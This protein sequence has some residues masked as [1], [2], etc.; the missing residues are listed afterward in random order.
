MLSTE[1]GA[2]LLQLQYSVAV[3]S[4][5]IGIATF[6]SVKYWASLVTNRALFV[7]LQY[8]NIFYL[9]ILCIITIWTTIAMFL[10][11]KDVDW[12]QVNYGCCGHVILH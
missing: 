4:L 12:S 5:I 3:L 7:K 8:I 9:C 1:Y 2:T 10:T 6:F 11:F